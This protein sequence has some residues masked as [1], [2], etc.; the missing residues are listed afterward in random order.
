M[1]WALDLQSFDLDLRDGAPYL[2][3]GLRLT[4]QR[5]AVALAVHYGEWYRN[6]EFGT[7]YRDRVFGRRDDRVASAELQRVING[8]EGVVRIDRFAFD[9]DSNRHASWTASVI[10]TDGTL[11]VTATPTEVSPA[12]WVLVFSFGGPTGGWM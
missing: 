8:V 4:A 1:D 2:V 3:D 11:E 10:G 12:V 7:R 9:V 6:T 5:I